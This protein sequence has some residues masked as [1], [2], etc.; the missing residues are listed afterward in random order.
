[1]QVYDKLDSC[2]MLSQAGPASTVHQA[3]PGCAAHAVNLALLQVPSS[4]VLSC[5]A[6]LC[7]SDLFPVQREVVL[8]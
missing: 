6:S 3:L 2:V 4:R 8:S 7:F 5:I 1:M